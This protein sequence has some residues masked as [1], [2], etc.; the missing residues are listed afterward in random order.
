MLDISKYPR[1]LQD[2]KLV[3]R[4]AFLEIEWRRACPDVDLQSQLGWCSYWLGTSDKGRKRVDMARTL[5][6]WFKKNQKDFE[7]A[8]AAGGSGPIVF[9]PKKYVEEKP[10]EGEVMTEEDFKKMREEIVR[11]KM[12]GVA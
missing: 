9:K 10:A 4:L 3:K 6:N 7:E 1:F 2:T 5:S 12:K 8:K 11:S